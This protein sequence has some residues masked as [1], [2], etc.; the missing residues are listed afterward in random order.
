MNSF[1]VTVPCA[2]DIVFCCCCRLLCFR[3]YVVSS[4]YFS[5]WWKQNVWNVFFFLVP[6]RFPRAINRSFFSLCMCVSVHRHISGALIP[7][8]YPRLILR[9]FR[10]KCKYIWKLY[11]CFTMSDFHGFVWSSLLTRPIA[12]C[13]CSTAAWLQ[14][15]WIM[16][17]HFHIPIR[18]LSA[19]LMY[20]DN[21]LVFPTCLRRRSVWRR[22][23]H[24]KYDNRWT[25]SIAIWRSK[26]FIFFCILYVSAVYLLSTQSR[27]PVHLMHVPVVDGAKYSGVLW[28]SVLQLLMSITPPLSWLLILLL[29]PSYC[30]TNF[31]D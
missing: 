9:Y 11:R 22:R 13:F 28:T 12:G 8:G 17:C 1:T 6:T 4:S 20:T 3:C 15:P 21:F 27:S 2:G 19:R 26:L 14:I 16:V 5:I 25:G 18:R 29:L 31:G 24:S 30:C 23:C 7:L 10:P